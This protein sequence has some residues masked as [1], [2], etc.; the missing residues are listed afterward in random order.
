MIAGVNCERRE[1]MRYFDHA[2]T[3]P[4]L[5]QAAQAVGE[6]MARFGNPSAR[7]ELGRA[8]AAGLEDARQKVADALGCEA[9]EV[10]FTSGGTEGDNWA[11]SAAKARKKGHIITSAVEHSAVLEPVKALAQQGY[12]VTYLPVDAAGQ[13]SPDDLSAALR[14]D[15]V[16]L[17]LMLV[18]NETGAVEPV[19]E[20]VRR[21]KRFDSRIFCHTDAVQGFLKLPFTPKELGVDALTISGHKIGA[22]KGIGAMYLKKG[23]KLKPF[24]LGGEQEGGLRSGTEPTVLAAGLGAA[25]EYGKEN[26]ARDTAALSAIRDYAGARLLAQVPQ[27]Q[28]VC[29]GEAPHILAVTLPGYKS[30]VVVRFLNDKGFCLSSG[31]ACHRGRP[32]HVYAALGLPKPWLDGML[33]LSFGPENTTGDVDALADALREAAESLFTTLS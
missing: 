3:T 24:I 10:I 13:V 2:A 7:Y 27:L 26:F 19:G 20:C 28:V 12:E 8:A 18:N 21:A 17:S 15:T 25:A 6:A 16:L 5:P 31:S 14:E 9:R 4:V 29:R 22:P 33:R 32:S 1:H 23:V 11:I 30:E